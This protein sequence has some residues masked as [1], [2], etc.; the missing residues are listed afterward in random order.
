MN[1]IALIIFTVLLSLQPGQN[2]LFG[3]LGGSQ[4]YKFL[5]LPPSSRISALGGSLIPVMDD[6]VNQMVLNP[7]SLSAKAHNQISF[8][9]A[10]YFEGIK[11]GYLGYAR[12]YDSI[13]TT[14][15]V[16]IQFMSYGKFTQTNDLGHVIGSF[17]A[18]EYALNLS[19]ARQYN[20]FNYGMSLKIITSSLESY[21]SFGLAVDLGVGFTDSAGRFMAAIVV[22]NLGTQLSTYRSGN[23][24]PLPLNIQF[25]IAR[26]FAHLPFRFSIV[27]H[28]LQKFNIRYDDPNV[29][30]VDNS[31]I[32]D[33]SGQNKEK[34][35]IVDKI[36]RHL[37][38]GGEFLIG[39]G[40]RLRVGYNHQR[41]QELKIVDKSAMAG[42][43]FGVGIKIVK[44][45]LDYS[46]AS[47]HLAGASHQFSLS[48]NLGE[49]IPG[50]R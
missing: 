25:G 18:G 22:N 14:F 30:Q 39:P 34:S 47:Y 40:F 44:F 9:T 26:Q 17:K 37:I 4:T 29:Q 15:G 11:F 48:A 12:H 45:R 31:I 3:Q 50:L 28:N 16:G 19:A 1:K 2:L 27:L 8:N 20:R 33:T 41:R 24:E 46:L 43:S 38:I 10:L 5:S 23:K 13:K 35:Y 42:F 21:N 32:G 36:A 6:D 7:A 49:F